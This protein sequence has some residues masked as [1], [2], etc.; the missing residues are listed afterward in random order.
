MDPS[1]VIFWQNEIKTPSEKN[2]PT[3]PKY[4]KKSSHRATTLI[5]NI[6]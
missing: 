6:F 1:A 3:I 2:K 4:K 5:A